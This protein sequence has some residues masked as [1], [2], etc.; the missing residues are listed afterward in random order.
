LTLRA[1]DLPHTCHYRWEGTGRA[2]DAVYCLTIRLETERRPTQLQSKW[3]GMKRSSLDKQLI[4]HRKRLCGMVVMLCIFGSACKQQ[5]VDVYG[6]YSRESPSLKESLIL[7]TNNTYEHHIYDTN[8]FSSI[9]TNFWSFSGGV[10]RFR[11]FYCSF[12]EIKGVDN[13]PPILFT[14]IDFEP[15]KDLLIRDFDRGYY[16]RRVLNSTNR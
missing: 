8:G 4:F 14:S 5:R 15:K 2:E 13:L 9:V 16:F 11:S 10:I 6:E 7:R 12:D 3:S 1:R